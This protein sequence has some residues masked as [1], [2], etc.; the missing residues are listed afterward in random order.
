M[1]YD[2]IHRKILQRNLLK[3]LRFIRFYEGKKGILFKQYL[4]SLTCGY[5]E[6]QEC[7]FLFNWTIYLRSNNNN[8]TLGT[9]KMAATSGFYVGIL[10]Q[11]V[12]N[13]VVL[14]Y[15]IIIAYSVSTAVISVLLRKNNLGMP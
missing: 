8:N 5:D 10:I 1:D 7:Q 11:A 3:I 12:I 6:K 13:A 15:N 2:F 9:F 14:Y 4:R